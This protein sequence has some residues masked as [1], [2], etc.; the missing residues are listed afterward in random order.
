[1][2]VAVETAT[3]SQSS[4]D[5]FSVRIAGSDSA[6]VEFGNASVLT[7]DATSDIIGLVLLKLRISAGL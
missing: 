5:T 6:L 2:L 3:V 7:P 4:R 1:M